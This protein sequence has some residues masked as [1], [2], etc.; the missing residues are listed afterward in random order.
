VEPPVSQSYVR[1]ARVAFF[2]VTAGGSV[3]A[4]TV[5]AAVLHPV[6]ALAVG[7]LLGAAVGL[8]VALLVRVWPVLRVLWWWAGEITAAVLL[9]ERSAWLARATVPCVSVAMLTL[10][11]GVVAAVGPL[12][13]FAVTWGWCAGPAQPARA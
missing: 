12:R 10:L 8:V 4:A 5:L 2:A 6:Q 13:R 9:L 3:V 1:K 11:A 7:G